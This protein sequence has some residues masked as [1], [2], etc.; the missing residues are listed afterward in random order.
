V[1]NILGREAQSELIEFLAKD[2]LLVF[3]YDGTLCPIVA[4]ASQ[5]VISP[6]TRTLLRSLCDSSICI[7]LSGR[8]RKDVLPLVDGIPFA[9][10]VGSHGEDWLVPH[11]GEKARHAKMD[12][13][14][15]QLM[16]EIGHLE[17]VVVENKG[18]SLSVHYRHARNRRAA[19]TKIVAAVARLRELRAIGGKEVFNLLPR[20][21]GGK[22]EALRDLK[23]MFGKRE[24]LFVGDDMTDEDGFALPARER[25]FKIRVGYGAKSRA[26]YYIPSQKDIGKL[27]KIIRDSYALAREAA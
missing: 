15:R 18:Y 17:G 19:K 16:A 12:R 22:G 23:K 8:A 24:A 20:E 6:E 21:S 11:A 1:R 5:A 13:A 25:I 4:H 7:L 14:Y 27:L 3:D 2:P 10:V 26:D 9:Q